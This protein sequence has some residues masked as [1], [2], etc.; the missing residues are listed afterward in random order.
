MYDESWS[1]RKYSMSVAL[2][3]KFFCIGI[4]ESALSS[5]AQFEFEFPTVRDSFNA[6]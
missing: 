4:K 6:C 5:V 1:L 3:G 2:S